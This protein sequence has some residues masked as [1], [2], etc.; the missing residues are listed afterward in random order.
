MKK[1]GNCFFTNGCFSLGDDGGIDTD[2]FFEDSYE[3]TKFIDKIL[4]K[5]D[6][7]P[8]IYY[9]GFILGILERSNE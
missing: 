6:D 1:L 4:Y 9:T 2:N 5:Y 7:H 3:L 8:S